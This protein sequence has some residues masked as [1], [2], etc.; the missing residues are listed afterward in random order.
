MSAQLSMADL[1]TP[2]SEVTFVAIDLE[3][4]G[5][6]A[7]SGSS[8]TEIGAVKYRG[9]IEI[10]SFQTF[11]NPEESIPAY[12]TVLTG[13]TDAMV[14]NAPKISEAF[15]PLL[16]FLGSPKETVLIAHNAPFDISFLRAAASELTYK[17]PSYRVFDSARLARRALTRE[18]VRDCK[19]A[20]LAG[21]FTTQVQPNHRALS[22]AQATIEVWHGLLERLGSLNI[23]TLEDLVDFSSQVTVEQRNKRHLMKDLP[24]SPGVYIFRDRL[25]NP[26]YI[27]TSKNLKARVRSYFSA[28]ETRSRIR[29]MVAIAEKIDFIKCAT[30]IEAQIRELRLIS[31][32][33]PRYNRRSRFQEKAIWVKLTNESFPRLMSARGLPSKHN[34][35]VAFGPF[36]SRES[37]QNAIDAL[38]EVVNLRQCN[39]RNF[40]QSRKSKSACAL[41]DMNKCGGACIGKEN[42]SNYETHVK[43]AIEYIS[44]NTHPVSNLLSEKM[45]GFATD[46]RFEEAAAIKQ[47]LHSF[48]IAADRAQNLINFVKISEILISKKVENEIEIIHIKHG[49]LVGSAIANPMTLFD[50]VD[51]LKQSS[52]VIQANDSLLPAATY[53]ESE[54]LLS[55]LFS[56]Q[57]EILEISSEW[58]LPVNGSGAV[59]HITP[60]FN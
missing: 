53:E 37:A 1:G 49:R 42:E 2:L 11:V 15:P 38:H 44:I 20:T 32:K 9:G 41:F 4:T 6:S 22:D 25:N 10:G 28:A 7:R 13:I 43:K 3:T 52:E 45:A 40:D 50:V 27:G 36:N 19:L 57:F 58:T 51:S 18:E 14:I 35:K 48:L 47:R 24:S 5:S 17:W 16:E 29:E 8:I 31:E 46:E 21:Y 56:D 12:I 60:A 33:Q 39:N 59:R 26:L 34:S 55:Y 30:V 23:S 54:K